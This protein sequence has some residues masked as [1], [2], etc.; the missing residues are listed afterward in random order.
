MRVLWSGFGGWRYFDLSI[1][2]CVP[3]SQNVDCV[4]LDFIAQFIVSNMNSPDFSGLKLK[5]LFA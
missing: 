3:D 5:E 4:L 2:A 1:F